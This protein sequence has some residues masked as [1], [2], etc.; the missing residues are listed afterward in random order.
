MINNCLLASRGGSSKAPKKLES[1]KNT[2]KSIEP[3]RE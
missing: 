1:D 3:I 2:L